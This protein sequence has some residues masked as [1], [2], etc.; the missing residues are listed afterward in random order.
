MRYYPPM[1]TESSSEP[2]F[3]IKIEDMPAL[4]YLNAEHARPLLAEWINRGTDQKMRR[5]MIDQLLRTVHQPDPSPS[6]AQLQQNSGLRAVFASEAD[7]D[8]FATAFAIARMQMTSAHQHMVAVM[9]DDLAQAERAVKGL[10]DAGVPDQAITVFSRA[11][12]FSASGHDWRGHSLGDVAAAVARGGLTGALV[13]IGVIALAPIAAPAAAL[14]SI[15]AVFGATG[16]A[17]HRMLTDH[18]VDGR[19]ANYYEKQIRRGRVFVS[20]DTRQ[21]PA[22]SPEISQIVKAV[23]G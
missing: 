6:I 1:A 5:T 13:G 3:V 10:H 20:V 14:A 22:G 21:V 23:I 16:G 9:F 7:R 12:E 17:M 19:E 4:N 18:D 11:G 15:T 2:A 8:N